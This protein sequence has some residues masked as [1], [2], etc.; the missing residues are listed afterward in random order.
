M[1][2]MVPHAGKSGMLAVRLVHSLPPSLV[3][4]TC[5]SLVPTQIIPACNGDSSIAKSVDPSKVIK[6]STA[7]PPELC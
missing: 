4:C 5:P 7:T 3:N 1:L 2:A 6:L